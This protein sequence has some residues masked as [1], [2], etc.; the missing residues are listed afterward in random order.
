MKSQERSWEF[1]RRWGTFRKISISAG[2]L[3]LIMDIF[4]SVNNADKLD[5]IPIARDLL[6]WDLNQLPHQGPPRNQKMVLRFQ[7]FLRS[8]KGGQTLWSK[9]TVKLI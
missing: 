8:V 7:Q 3:T 4:I 1:Q 5:A 2:M 9:K 6:D